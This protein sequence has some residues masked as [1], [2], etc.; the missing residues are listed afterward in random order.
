MYSYN[1]DPIIEMLKAH[2]KSAK[3]EAHLR[4]LLKVL[5]RR[6][7]KRITTNETLKVS[8]TIYPTEC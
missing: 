1:T 4:H 6:S 3:H 8:C 7:R 5:R 2:Q